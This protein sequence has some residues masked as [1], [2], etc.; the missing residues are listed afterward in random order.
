MMRSF[1][2]GIRPIYYI[3]KI[4]LTN[5]GVTLRKGKDTPDI[6]E[7]PISFPATQFI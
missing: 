2:F 6:G 4:L 3:L 7:A 1:L 5:S